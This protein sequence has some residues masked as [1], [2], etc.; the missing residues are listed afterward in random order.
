MRVPVLT[1]LYADQ[2][3]S[4]SQ[5]TRLGDEKARPIRR[6]LFQLLRQA[7]LDA[8][9]RVVDNT[10][11]GAV[12]AFDSAVAAASSALRLQSDIAAINS[13]RPDD[14]RLG[15]RVGLHSGEPVE[16]D[17]GRLFGAAVVVAAR[18]CAVARAGQILASETVRALA[19][20]AGQQSYHL[21]GRMVLKG[22]GEPTTLFEVTQAGV[23]RPRRPM[24]LAP[25]GGLVFVGVLVALIFVPRTG[26]ASVTPSNAELAAY[27][28]TNR[29]AALLLS[30]INALA[31]LVFGMFVLSLA[32]ALGRSALAAGPIARATL[33]TGLGGGALALLSLVLGAVPAFR[34]AASGDLA[35]TRT[36]WDFSVFV[37]ALSFAF[38]AGL[39]G[40]ASVGILRWKTVPAWIGY[41]GLLLAV[42]ATVSLSLVLI[43]VDGSTIARQLTF[44]AFLVWVA[45]ASGALLQSP[46]LRA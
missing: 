26:I 6:E 1:V 5:L 29:G 13:S 39:A 16:G 31:I 3:E 34:L 43:D 37:D 35:A 21:L 12:C 20:P 32:R 28:V 41:F 24:A 4:T 33:W 45:T 11:D 19:A 7:V 25:L 10:G 23:R 27:Y 9:G 44:L 42:A 14:E 18:L 38:M 30:G 2:A 36:L 46:T 17:D 40:V 8:G 22:L 15:V